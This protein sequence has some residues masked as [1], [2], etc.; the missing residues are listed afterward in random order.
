MNFY[1]CSQAGHVFFQKPLSPKVQNHQDL[2]RD[3]GEEQAKR[4][5][6]SIRQ[7]AKKQDTKQL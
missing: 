4:N 3:E 5:N 7:L 2:K 1:I 6:C